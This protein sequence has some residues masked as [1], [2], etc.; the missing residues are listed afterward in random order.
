[1]ALVLALAYFNM[2]YLARR[3]KLKA[4][5][6]LPLKASQSIFLASPTYGTTLCL[7]A[8]GSFSKVMTRVL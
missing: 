2:A 1:M 7:T 8:S 4:M 3:V 5:P 6:R